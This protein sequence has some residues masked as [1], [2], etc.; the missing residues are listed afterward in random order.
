M[1]PY[2]VDLLDAGWSRLLGALLADQVLGSCALHDLFECSLGVVRGG[3]SRQTTRYSGLLACEDYVYPA[4][5]CIVRW[6]REVIQL[7]DGSRNHL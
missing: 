2:L 6:H 4:S 5:S 7:S 1:V 3:L